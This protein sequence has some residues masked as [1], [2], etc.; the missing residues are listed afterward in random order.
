MPSAFYFPAGRNG[1]GEEADY[2]NSVL[3]A[4]LATFNH[5]AG[6]LNF[7]FFGALNLAVDFPGQ[8]VMSATFEGIGLA[9][10]HTE[11]WGHN[12]WLRGKSCAYIGGVRSSVM[13]WMG[14]GK[15]VQ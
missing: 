8:T 2:W 4:G 7:A 3:R 1:S 15:P 12:W 11:N 13:G 5:D 10:G 9:Q 6:Q 14:M